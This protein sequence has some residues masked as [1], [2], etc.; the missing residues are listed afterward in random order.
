MTA[1]AATLPSSV[2]LVLDDEPAIC[3][4]LK[5][6]LER[7]DPSLRVLKAQSPSA[8]IEILK[9]HAVDLIISDFRMPEMDGLAFL[10]EAQ[11][12]QPHAARMLVTAYADERMIIRSINEVHVDSVFTKPWDATSV[13]DVVGS[14]VHA[15]RQRRQRDAAFTRAAEICDGAV[16]QDPRA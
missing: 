13:R 3:D 11:R 15:R 14:I 8:A 10:T 6:L 7:A 1:E 5:R 12:L 2:V 9:T 4:S 16:K